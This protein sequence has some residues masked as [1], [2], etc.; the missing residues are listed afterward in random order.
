MLP[1]AKL[2]TYS[3]AITKWWQPC[4]NFIKKKA[5]KK[6]GRKRKQGE[7]GGALLSAFFL[8]NMITQH[9]FGCQEKKGYTILSL[10]GGS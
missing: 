3:A 9:T 5:P 1:P 6:G 4:A 10:V 2:A 7:G 8:L